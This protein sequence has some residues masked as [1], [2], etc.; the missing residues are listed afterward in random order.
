[1]ELGTW[2]GIVSGKRGIGGGILGRIEKRERRRYHRRGKTA[3]GGSDMTWQGNFVCATQFAYTF[4]V[5]VMDACD[6]LDLTR[7]SRLLRA[8]CD[9]ALE[10][11]NRLIVGGDGKGQVRLGQVEFDGALC[12]L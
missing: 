6:A 9:D 7:D 2:I 11:C 3:G 1:L 10:N 8:S 5:S 4:C 12:T